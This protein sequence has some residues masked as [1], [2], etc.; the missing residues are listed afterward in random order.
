[1]ASRYPVMWSKIIANW[2]SPG[3]EDRAWLTYSA[4]YLFRTGNVRWAIDPLTLHRRV[5]QTP[6]VDIARDLGKLSYVLLTHR[7][8]DHLDLELLASLREFPIQWVVPEV[9]LSSV[10][11][12]AGLAYDKIIVPVPMQRINLGRLSILPFE[13]LHMEFT[14]QG[15]SKGVPS[16]AYLVEFSG[17]RWL[18]PGDTRTFDAGQIPSMGP[19]DVLFAHL[20][21]GRAA[22]LQDDPPLLR[23]F[24]QFC[25]DLHPKRV[26][27]T[28][29]EELGRDANDYWDAQHFEKVRATLQE[30]ACGMP[31]SAALMG[32]GLTL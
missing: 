31:V 4:N 7:H 24:C 22:A 28:H 15:T 11:K 13:G 5:T 23:S 20:W 2:S 29:L 26:I 3:S 6:Q 19:V 16:M 25:A 14:L 1:M 9:I 32:D 17:K 27:I 21:L 30:I 10:M 18:F 12:Q 8:E